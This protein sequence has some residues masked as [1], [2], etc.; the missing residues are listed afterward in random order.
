MTTANYQYRA[1]AANMRAI[2]GLTGGDVGV[3][4]DEAHMDPPAGY[5]VSPMGIRTAGR[6]D[7]DYSTRQSRDRLTPY[8]ESAS[9]WDVGDNWPNG[10]RAAWLRWNNKLLNG[11]MARDPA[12][13][14]LRAINFSRDGVERKRYDTLHP[15]MGIIPSTDTV[16]IHTHGETWRDTIGSA[17]LDRTFRRIEQMARDAINNISTP[18][19]PSLAQEEEH[20]MSNLIRWSGHGAVFRS[21]GINARWIQ[22]EAW[23]NDEITLQ[24]DGT[25]GTDPVHGTGWE[26]GGAV[27]VVD[28]KELIGL[29][30]GPVPEGWDPIVTPPVPA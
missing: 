16:T 10:G 15:E 14:A 12:L 1:F 3:V 17:A 13:S 4:P 27:R 28:R 24:R 18:Q 30:V 7:R 9:A 26:Y 8:S 25:Y 21:N 11:L 29:I 6:W 19:A 22:T 5:H 23:L 2:T 20:D